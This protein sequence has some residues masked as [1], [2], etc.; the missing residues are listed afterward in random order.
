MHESGHHK[1]IKRDH[2]SV[3]HGD[4]FLSI[5]LHPPPVTICLS[6]CCLFLKAFSPLVNNRELC[7][8]L[9]QKRNAICEKSLNMISFF[10]TE[11]QNILELYYIVTFLFG[12]RDFKL[13]IFGWVKIFAYYLL[14]MIDVFV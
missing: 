7:K 2:P 4:P 13:N 1:C 5:I 8:K 10:F 11:Q 6:K 14:E 3:G 12:I 9:E